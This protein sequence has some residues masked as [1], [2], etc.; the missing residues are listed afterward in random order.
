MRVAF[1]TVRS[2]VL[3]PVI[4]SVKV[5]VTVAVSP[6]VAGAALKGP[7]DRLLRDLGH[8]ASVVGVARLYA[9]VAATLVI[10]DADAAWNDTFVH[11]DS[12]HYLFEGSRLK[13]PGLMLRG[14]VS[15]ETDVG[16]YVTKNPNAN[17][18]FVGAQVQRSLAT[19]ATTP[20]AW[21]ST[22]PAV[23]CRSR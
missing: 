22:R 16:L 20:W 2:A 7:A 15:A 11:P 14:G 18:G 12:A 5:K 19:G 3:K 8:E 6:I 1:A 10:D 9:E 13:F 23:H 21:R 17:Y 4:A